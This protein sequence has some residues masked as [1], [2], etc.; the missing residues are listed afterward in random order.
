MRQI[1]FEPVSR[2]QFLQLREA[3]RLVKQEFGEQL[4]L[5]ADDVLDHLFEFALESKSDKL[6]DVFAALKGP[7]NAEGGMSSNSPSQSSQSES[8][9]RTQ[10]GGFLRPSP[11]GN[12]TTNTPEHTNIKVGDVVEGKRCVAWYRGNPVFKSL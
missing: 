6:F 1:D 3:R 4:V 12:A 2:D 5:N 7:A 10:I 9:G 8:R 11:S